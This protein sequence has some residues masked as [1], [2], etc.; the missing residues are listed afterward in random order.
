[1]F[2]IIYNYWW[3]CDKEI[4]LWAEQGWL[5]IILYF[6]TRIF[7]Y[8]TKSFGVSQLKKYMKIE[9]F[10]GKLSSDSSNS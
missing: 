6:A 3:I 10:L 7:L 5:K 1:M 8:Y 2:N 9:I 4:F